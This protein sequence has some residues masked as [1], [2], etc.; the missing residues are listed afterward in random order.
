MVCIVVPMFGLSESVFRIYYELMYNGPFSPPSLLLRT[1]SLSH[2]HSLSPP[3]PTPSILCLPLFSLFPFCV[4]SPC[5]P[6]F[7]H[8]LSWY[9]QAL[10]GCPEFSVS[11]YMGESIDLEPFKI[12]LTSEETKPWYIYAVC[13]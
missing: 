13:V 2:T 6:P 4:L 1:L 8:Q 3:T 5:L 7:L 10:A 12:A 11:Q 9:Q